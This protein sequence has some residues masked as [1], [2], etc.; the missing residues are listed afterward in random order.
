MVDPVPAFRTPHSRDVFRINA[1]EKILYGQQV[2]LLDILFPCCKVK[3]RGQDKL[4]NI[5]KL[6][7]DT[8]VNSVSFGIK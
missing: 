1:E 5:S 6:L 2:L 3:R 8:I 4:K 7:D